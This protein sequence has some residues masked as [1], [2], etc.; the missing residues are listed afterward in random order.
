MA[1]YFSIFPKILY[2]F[3]DYKNSEYITNILSRFSFEESLKNNFSAYFMYTIK[4]DETPEIIASKYY[5]SPNKH[6]IILMMND[7]IDPQF[8]WPLTY[9]SLDSYID[10]KYM[11]MANS[12]TSGAGIDWSKSNN[13]AYYM[14]EKTITP[15]NI[16]TINQYEIDANTYA[17]TTY[18]SSNRTLENGDIITLEI[19]KTY[20]TYYDYEIE[21]NDS[22][23]EIKLLKREFLVPIENEIRKVFE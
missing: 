1:N 20:N 9:S 21:Q 4:D 12:N 19:D 23:R 16:I 14:T 11:E 18:S 7:I 6:W 2:S 17:N 13:I 3:D 10:V 22:K 8:D 15:D 5:D